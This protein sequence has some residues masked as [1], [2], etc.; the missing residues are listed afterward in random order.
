MSCGV[1]CRLSSD[2]LLLWLW[3]RLVAT[4]PIGPLAWDPPYAVEAAL[5]KAKKKK[6][7]K[8]KEKDKSWFSDTMTVKSS[9]YR[10]DRSPHSRVHILSTASRVP[11]STGLTMT[12][13]NSNKTA[14][15]QSTDCVPGRVP[16]AL[17][18]LFY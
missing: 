15:T 8:E 13:D 5:E 4:A 12:C 17:H 10:K 9:F 3:C 1:G 18:S 14:I 2:P 11:M 6:R 7:K 16:G